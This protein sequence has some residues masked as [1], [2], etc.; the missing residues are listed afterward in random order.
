MLGVGVPNPST[1]LVPGTFNS[2]DL[3]GLSAVGGVTRHGM[4]VRSEAPIAIGPAGERMLHALNFRTTIDL[5][6]PVERERD[7]VKFSGLRCVSAPLFSGEVDVTIARPLSALYMEIIE[8]CGSRFAV[9]ATALARTDA[10]PAIVYCSAG[11]DRTGLAVALILSAAGVDD[12]AIAADFVRTELA[13]SPE[14]RRDLEG[15]ARRA[16]V[17]E[18]VLALQMEAPR[19][20]ITSVLSHIQRHFGGAAAYL[21]AYGCPESHL[22]RLRERLIELR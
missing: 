20:A 14:T 3:G 4:L 19:E 9:V 16:G 22:S 2:R 6:E 10:L 8:R 17:S 1:P 21:Q 13:L 12:E 5:R 7:P 18:A 15:R 11:K